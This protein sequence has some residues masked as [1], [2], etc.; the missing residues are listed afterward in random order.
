MFSWYL[1]GIQLFVILPLSNIIT[2]NEKQTRL[3]QEMKKQN[4]RYFLSENESDDSSEWLYPAL[5]Q[6]GLQEPVMNVVTF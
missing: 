6:R 2:Y 3:F 4:V 1:A 5:L